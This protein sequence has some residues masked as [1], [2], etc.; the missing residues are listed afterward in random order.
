MTPRTADLWGAFERL[1]AHQQRVVFEMYWHGYSQEECAETMG[2]SPRAVSHV[3][4]AAAR[5]YEK[6][7]SEYRLKTK[8]VSVLSIET[9]DE[10]A[11]R[12]NGQRP[13]TYKAPASHG[14][15]A[16][17]CPQPDT[18]YE[19][20]ERDAFIKELSWCAASPFLQLQNRG[21]YNERA[22]MNRERIARDQAAER[23]ERRALQAA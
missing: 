9:A 1:T 2:I 12:G 21:G 20:P 19:T 14:P 8:S 17:L 18:H 15:P 16:S 11:E 23:E 3:L 6:K 22:R 7:F 5:R 4:T 13:D 10:G